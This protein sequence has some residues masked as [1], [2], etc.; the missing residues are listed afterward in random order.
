MSRPS[1]SCVFCL[2]NLVT[3]IL[4]FR[5]PAAGEKTTGTGT[6]MFDKNGT[7]GSMFKGMPLSPSPLILSPNNPCYLYHVRHQV[8]SCTGAN[9]RMLIQP[10][11]RLAALGKALEG[12]WTRT[13][14]SGNISIPMERLEA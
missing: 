7:I 2:P 10:T 14:P 12:R 11:A 6:S 3:V 1:K 13:E 5:K 9:Q 4:T 8:V